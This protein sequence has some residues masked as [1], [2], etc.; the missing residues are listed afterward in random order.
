MCFRSCN[1]VASRLAP[2]SSDMLCVPVRQ[3]RI[4]AAISPMAKVTTQAA[5]AWLMAS[6]CG[7]GKR[8]QEYQAA[9]QLKGV[10]RKMALVPH[11]NLRSSAGSQA[12]AGVSR[13][14][15]RTEMQAA[16]GSARVNM[17]HHR[18]TARPGAS[19][20][21]TARPWRVIASHLE[22]LR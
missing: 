1:S 18:Q 20:G 19:T 7:S 16:S 6:A 13:R 12:K 15:E 11:P 4:A 3:P 8:V 2:A 22:K 17:R 10:G 9:A 5:P 21:N 14:V